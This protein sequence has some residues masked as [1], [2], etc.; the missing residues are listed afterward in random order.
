MER[1]EYALSERAVDASRLS[2]RMERGKLLPTVGLGV[3]GMYANLLDKN[4]THG[5]LYATVSVPLSAWWGGSHAIHKARYNL[6][7]AELAV[8]DARQ[9]LTLDIQHAWNSLVEAY[10]QISVAR[11]SIDSARE[12]YRQQQSYY[13]NGTVPMTDLLQAESQLL[14]TESRLT[15]ATATYYIRLADYQRKTRVYPGSE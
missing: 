5:L 6:Q 7:Q 4:E 13:R 12:N 1:K 10:R 8:A 14:Q 2:L 3:Q 11:R 9:N 15:S